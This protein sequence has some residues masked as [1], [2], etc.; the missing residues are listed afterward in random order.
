MPSIT[1]TFKS[2]N[3]KEEHRQ[4][5]ESGV[6]GVI[7]YFDRRL[8]QRGNPYHK[9][10]WYQSPRSPESFSLRIQGVMLMTLCWLGL[11]C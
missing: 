7:C 11:V 10:R 8:K 5:T 4:G 9:A 3:K 2:G 6:G 1:L